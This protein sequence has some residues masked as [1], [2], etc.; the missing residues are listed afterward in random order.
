M[1]VLSARCSCDISQSHRMVEI[2]MSSRM[3]LL[4]VLNISLLIHLPF[5]YIT[6]KILLFYNK[7]SPHAIDTAQGDFLSFLI[8]A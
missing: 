4:Q 2:V 1:W 5:D 8:V 7:K 6:H 3:I